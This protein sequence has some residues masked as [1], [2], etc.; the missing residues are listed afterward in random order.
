MT[1]VCDKVI[2]QWEHNGGTCLEL[3]EDFGNQVRI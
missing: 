1:K 3:G 2:H